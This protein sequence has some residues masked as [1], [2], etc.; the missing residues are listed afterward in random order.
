MKG[1]RSA[2][3]HFLVD[4]FNEILKTE[5]TLVS[6]S[7]FKDLSLREMH[8]IEA[9]CNAKGNSE[10][11]SA[12]SIAAALRITAGTL[13]TTVSLLEKKGYLLRQR[14]EKDK[15]IVRIFATEDG[16]SANLTH[17]K[18]HEE[19]VDYVLSALSPE[20]TDLFIR[21]LGSVSSFFKSK[22]KEKTGGNP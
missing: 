12:A 10:N 14:D 6:N 8:V 2:L 11:N 22:Y 19:M 15:R 9:V 17:Q 20:E 3:N 13:T 5:E 18:F 4:V 7:G 21:A 1:N 16:L